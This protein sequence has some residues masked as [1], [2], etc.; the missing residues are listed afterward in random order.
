MHMMRK[1]VFNTGPNAGKPA[2]QDPDGAAEETDAKPSG[3]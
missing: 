3:G 2:K 1:N